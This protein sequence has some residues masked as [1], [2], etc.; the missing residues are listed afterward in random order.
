[1]IDKTGLSLS[2]TISNLQSVAL[3]QFISQSPTGDASNAIPL[4]IIGLVCVF[5]GVCLTTIPETLN[6]NLPQTIEDAENFGKYQKYWAL[7][8]SK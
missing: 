4:L 7:A 8:K 1:M 2:A 3:S 5:S 6:E